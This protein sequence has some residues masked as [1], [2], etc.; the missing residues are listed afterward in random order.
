MTLNPKSG[1]YLADAPDGSAV[2][3]TLQGRLTA[4][5]GKD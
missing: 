4:D 3:V 1:V 5:R 2:R